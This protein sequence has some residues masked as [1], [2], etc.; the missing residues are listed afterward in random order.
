MVCPAVSGTDSEQAQG[1][2]PGVL[3][4]APPF[5]EQLDVAAA[6]AEPSAAAA[7]TIQIP[8]DGVAINPLAAQ[9]AGLAAVGAPPATGAATSGA[10]GLTSGAAERSGLDAAAAV[11]MLTVSAQAAAPPAVSTSFGA[12][13]HDRV[14]VSVS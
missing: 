9:S 5:G 3:S 14:R 2:S 13:H 12:L 4:P 11:Q 8:A 6:S 7:A 10:G 1:V